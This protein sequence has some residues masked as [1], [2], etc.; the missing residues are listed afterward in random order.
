MRVF[1][2]VFC[3]EPTP[4]LFFS[5]SRI[6]ATA[7]PLH[8][9]NTMASKDAGDDLTE[10]AILDAFQRYAT[11]GRSI[12][13]KEVP[14]ILEEMDFPPMTREAAAN[15]VA[16]YDRNHNGRLECKEFEKLIK[17][18]IWE[19][20]LAHGGTNRRASGAVA[21]PAEPTPAAPAAA[22]P[23]GLVESST[24]VREFSL[25]TDPDSARTAGASQTTNSAG[26]APLAAQPPPPPPPAEEVPASDGNGDAATPR[27]DGVLAEEGGGDVQPPDSAALAES[28]PPP[29]PPIPTKL[30]IAI[31]ASLISVGLLLVCILVPLHFSYIERGRMGF[32]KN[33]YTN[34][35]DRSRVYG[36]GRYGWG[37]GRVAITFPS[38]LQDVTLDL[39][40]FVEG[41]QIITV[42]FQFLYQLV[43]EKLSDLY[44]AFGLNYESRITSLA[45]ARLRNTAPQF[46]LDNY[47]LHRANVTSTYHADLQA[48]LLARGFVLVPREAFFVVGVKLPQ[49]L[50]QQRANLFTIT[51]Q[52]V[53]Q[54][55]TTNATLVRLETAQLVAA[56]DASVTFEKANATATSGA[57]VDTARAEA[58]AIVQSE[59]GAQVSNLLQQLGVA[60]DQ[61]TTASLMYYLAT[62][63][64]A[65]S[66]KTSYVR[67]PLSSNVYVRTP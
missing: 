9:V 31:A 19:R 16:Q 43:E 39:E 46:S 28:T 64:G 60:S 10:E 29:R 21:C 23:P 66:S 40:V 58:F 2:V 57:L 37:V 62:L 52:Q 45:L 18:K 25:A 47:T 51:Q 56:V 50:L 24:P 32:R 35:V 30:V 63:D 49:S 17:K 59:K 5:F 42:R 3:V 61:T 65:Q 4:P 27:N 1:V 22:S 15:L 12:P 67:A 53:T 33:T 7:V 44:L 14:R 8:T 11:G 13:A 34:D 54:V 41:G 6:E 36:S 38:T 55:Y 26:Q 48:E 20:K